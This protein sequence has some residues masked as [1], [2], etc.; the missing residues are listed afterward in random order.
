M[1]RAPGAFQDRLATELRLAGAATIEK[2]QAVLKQFLPRF[3][4]RFP[5]PP[6]CP[7]LAL[8]PL[9]PGLRLEQILCFKHRGWVARDNTV[10]YNGARCSGC[11]ASNAAAM[12]EQLW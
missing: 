7:D 9:E 8:Q 12:P 3:N 10:K 2:A 5:V 6:K 11:Q 1:K 4:R